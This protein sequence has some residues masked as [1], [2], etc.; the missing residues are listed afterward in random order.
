MFDCLWI[1][2]I[3]RM[4]GMLEQAL[5]HKSAEIWQSVGNSGG[6]LVEADGFVCPHDPCQ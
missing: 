6:V 3:R 4:C 2:L 5:A 1:A